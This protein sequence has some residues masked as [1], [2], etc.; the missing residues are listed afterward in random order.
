MS[1]VVEILAS[2]LTSGIGVAAFI[3]FSIRRRMHRANRLIAGRR[4]DVPSSWLWSPRRA[5]LLH[6]RLQGCCEV[7]LQSAARASS[8][9]PQRPSRRLSLRRARSSPGPFEPLAAELI[10]QAVDLDA[11][12]VAAD[13]R[14]GP[15][16]RRA[17]ADLAVQV[18][19][20]E[21]SARRMEALSHSWQA[22][23]GEAQLANPDLTDR[24]DAVEAALG[25]LR[26]PVPTAAGRTNSG[27]RRG[28]AS[29]GW[30]RTDSRTA[31]PASGG[32]GSPSEEPPDGDR[33]RRRS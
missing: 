27:P 13:R 18:Q 8:A 20:L 23:L 32:R 14:S 15:W 9:V 21:S 3:V 16:R 29:G 5:A 17:L 10:A 30:R 25:E 1:T 28:L 2:V 33:Y 7:A 24:L 19:R 26:D 22:Q 6:R 4:S 31:G 12:L 11:G